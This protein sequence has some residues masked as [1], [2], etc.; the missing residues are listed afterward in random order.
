MYDPTST[1]GP[2]LPQTSSDEDEPHSP[3]RTDPPVIDLQH[4]DNT[5]RMPHLPPPMDDGDLFPPP[6]D[7]AVHTAVRHTNHTAVAYTLH[8][9]RPVLATDAV[10][11]SAAAVIIDTGASLHL[12][13]HTGEAGFQGARRPSTTH[14]S[15]GMTARAPVDFEGYHVQYVLGDA[16][17]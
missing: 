7:R 2:G 5:V 12:E 17:D 1:P 8:G 3:P 4:L 13:N 9:V 11:D 10:D 15:T 14:I 16:P 6:H